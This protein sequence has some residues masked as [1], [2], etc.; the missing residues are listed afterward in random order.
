M[1]I[2]M[3]VVSTFESLSLFVVA[4]VWEFAPAMLVT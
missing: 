2:Y 3:K 4:V 1:D